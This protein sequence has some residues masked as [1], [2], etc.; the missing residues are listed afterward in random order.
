MVD[1][2]M[3]GDT[4]VF[5][6]SGHGTTFNDLDDYGRPTEYERTEALCPFDYS[7]GKVVFTDDLNAVCE[8]IPP[9]VYMTIF[10]DCS[11]SGVVTRVVTERLRSHS[12]PVKQASTLSPVYSFNDCGISCLRG[13]PSPSG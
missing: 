2:S 1:S 10:L 12:S 13:Q 3:A 5:H 9:S 4:L 6:F 8:G 7:E 11:F